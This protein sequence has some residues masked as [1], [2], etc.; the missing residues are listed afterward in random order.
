MTID[1]SPQYFSEDMR[2]YLLKGK[3]PQKFII[4][5]VNRCRQ[6]TADATKTDPQVAAEGHPS[7]YDVAYLVQSYINLGVVT[8]EEVGSCVDQFGL[9]PEEV[10]LFVSETLPEIRDYMEERKQQEL[11][12]AQ[13]RQIEAATQYCEQWGLARLDGIAAYYQQNLSQL[14]PINQYWGDVIKKYQNQ[15]PRLE[16][17]L[18]QIADPEKRA[19]RLMKELYYLTYLHPSEAKTVFEREQQHN[20]YVY[21]DSL[22]KASQVMYQTTSGKDPDLSAVRYG[23]GQLEVTVNFFSIDDPESVNR[24]IR[25]STIDNLV[26]GAKTPLEKQSALK[27]RIRPTHRM[28]KGQSNMPRGN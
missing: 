13:Q 25:S 15:R 28:E 11:Q 1:S 20:S 24:R 5:E 6:N 10:P 18:G 2:N 19:G 12:E 9:T 16:R 3:T 17:E 8:E 14:T 4:D 22:F 7:K 27:K 26:Y 21:L 23:A